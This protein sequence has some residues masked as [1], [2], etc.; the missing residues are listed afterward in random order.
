VTPSEV[1]NVDLHLCERAE[2]S[3]ERNAGIS[4]MIK[5]VKQP[6]SG[7]RGFIYLWDYLFVETWGLGYSTGQNREACIVKEQ[8]GNAT[9][10]CR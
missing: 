8:A 6:R 7:A 3:R 2:E 9:N 10:P 4:P 1:A 5:L